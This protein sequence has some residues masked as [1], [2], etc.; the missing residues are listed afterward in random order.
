MRVRILA[1]ILVSIMVVSVGAASSASGWEAI[2]SQTDS[3]LQMPSQ[4]VWQYNPVNKISILD[5]ETAELF[6]DIGAAF[7]LHPPNR[8]RKAKESWMIMI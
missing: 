5:S 4:N 7:C 2:D 3:A 1:L 8:K 6:N